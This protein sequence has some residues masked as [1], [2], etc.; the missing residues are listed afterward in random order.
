MFH[1]RSSNYHVPTSDL[2]GAV[3]SFT[4]S[5]ATFDLGKV[6]PR[7]VT[8]VSPTTES[9][10]RDGIFIVYQAFGQGSACVGMHVLSRQRSLA[11]LVCSGFVRRLVFGMVTL[12]AERGLGKNAFAPN[13]GDI[14]SLYT[15]VT[16]A[17]P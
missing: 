17:S 2:D 16:P 7:I 1:F 3:F 14:P 4:T 13:L 6:W 12:A 11:G 15:P 8:I 10:P 5:Q 9:R